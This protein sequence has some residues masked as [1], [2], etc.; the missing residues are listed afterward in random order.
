MDDPRCVELVVAVAANGVVE[1]HV[2]DRGAGF[3][4]AFLARAFDRFS[5][6]DESRG[7]RGAGLGLSIVELIAR[8]HGG[9]VGAANRSGGGADVW[10]TL[11]AAR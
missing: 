10:I 8:A 5:R 4:D 3:S 11:S 2:S 1:L 7:S 9:E 6:G